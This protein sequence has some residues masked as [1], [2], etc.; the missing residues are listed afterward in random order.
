MERGEDTVERATSI[1]GLAVLI[2]G[3]LDP[4]I[5]RATYQRPLAAALRRLELGVVAGSGQ[6]YEDVAPQDAQG[7]RRRAAL[8]FIELELSDP[9]AALPT[10]LDCLRRA[11]ARRGGAE[12]VAIEVTGADGSVRRAPLT[13]P[14]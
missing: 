7:A 5:R 3:D 2:T 10:V 13:R 11:A 1:K 9:I 14:L 8:S 4:K 12:R 6:V